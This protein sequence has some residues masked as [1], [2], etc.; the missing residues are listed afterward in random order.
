M[1]DPH[2]L[3]EVSATIK[4][5][6]SARYKSD[7]PWLV[8]RGSNANDL[9]ELVIDAFGLGEEAKTMAL[10]EVVAEAQS[11]ASAMGNVADGAG[12]K[13]LSSGAGGSAWDRAKS[14]DSKPAKEEKSPEEQERE[15]LTAEIQAASDIESLKQ[16]WA[17][18]QAAFKDETLMASWKA[19]GK[20]LQSG[21]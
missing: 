9:K 1:T 6:E 21:S 15:R 17:R 7:N 16:L 14:G 13:V 11:I 10:H 20:S 8:F 18:N 5:P 19:R 3:R 12:G 4:F 2:A